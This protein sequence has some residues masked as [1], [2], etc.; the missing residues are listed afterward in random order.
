M[1]LIGAGGHAKSIIDSVLQKKELDI[2]GILDDQSKVGKLLMGIPIIGT[3]DCMEE[4]YHKGVR[5]A[6]IAV[7]S[8]GNT[9]V[10][11]RIY[12]RLCQI[13]YSFPNIIDETAVLAQNVELETGNF[14]GKRAVVNASCRIG[15]QTII[16]SGAIIEHDCLIEDFVHI[17]PGA[18]IC[19]NVAIGRESHIGANSVVIQ[20][21]KIGRG[22][23]IGAGSV[24]VNEIEDYKKAYGNPCKE[25]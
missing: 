4:L 14:I 22:T 16:N 1:I 12:E 19:G 18:V 5:Q 13:G 17:S 25:V 24:V 3:D 11:K 9:K 8:V 23:L 20:G 6:F 15:N 10:R 2:I 7:G 21:R